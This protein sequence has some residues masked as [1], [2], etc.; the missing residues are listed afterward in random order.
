[1]FT[2]TNGRLRL[3]IGEDGTWLVEVDDKIVGLEHR[4]HFRAL[5]PLLEEEPRRTLRALNVA[6]E[7][8]HLAVSP[9]EELV[10][11]ALE[12]ASSYWK[13]LALYWLETAAP[14][15]DDIREHL[16]SI[17]ARNSKWPQPL[18][19]RAKRLLRSHSR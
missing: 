9:V 8:H 10:L 11:H 2:T 6:V 4:A 7:E 3:G 1:M 13:E 12:F 19:D 18:R 15:N 16:E 5:L 14:L 17:A